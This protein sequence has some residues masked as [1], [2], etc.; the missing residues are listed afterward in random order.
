MSA[1]LPARSPARDLVSV[2][3]P[4]HNAAD[5]LADTIA[6]A[7]DQTYAPIE[8]VVV[9][10]GSTDATATVAQG[11]GDRIVYVEQAN[12]GPAAA[13]NAALEV[14]TG[15]LVALLDADDL[16][17][18]E[19]VERCVA[20]LERR[21]EIGMV[22]TDAF[23]IENDVPTTKRSYIDR[24]KYPFPAREDGQLDE[25]ARRNFLFV[26][27]VF[28][29]VLVDRCGG[30]DE[31]IWG[32]EDYDLWARFLLT[33]TRAAFINE[34][35]GYYRRRTGSVSAS[36]RQWGEHLF[37]LEKH[38]PELWRRGARGRARDAYEIAQNLAARGDRRGAARFFA[39]AVVGEEASPAMRVKLAGGAI[40]QLVVP[41]RPVPDADQRERHAAPPGT[42]EQAR[43]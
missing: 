4:A 30:F 18:P 13:R 14:A 37:V 23:L 8:V 27:V 29:R 41:S 33:D 42:W 5:Y 3:I 1:A 2:I 15:Q 32:A 16:W 7:L 10:D 22:T 35:L 31:R 24:R 12:A 9:N 28:R 36:P 17:K 11:F 38:L 19:R 39:H 20:I 21:P 34:P 43:G 26:G 25:I 6:S 40:R